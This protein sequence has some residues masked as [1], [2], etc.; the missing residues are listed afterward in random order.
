MKFQDGEKVIGFWFVG[1]CRNYLM[2]RA[3]VK[4]EHLLFESDVML[5]DGFAPPEFSSESLMADIKKAS[6]PLSDVPTYTKEMQDDP[7]FIKS[8]WVGI[9]DGFTALGSL[10]AGK[11]AVAREGGAVFVSGPLSVEEANK[12]IAELPWERL[13]GTEKA[14]SC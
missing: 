11:A 1:S 12:K 5:E 13:M 10:F 9:H 4:D 8:M 14:A 3:F 6:F 2:F 7:K